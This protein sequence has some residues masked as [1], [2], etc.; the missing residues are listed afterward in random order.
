MEEINVRIREL[1]QEKFDVTELEIPNHTDFVKDLGID[2]LDLYELIL[3]V[4]KE[5]RITITDE[6]AEKLRT[7]G[8]LI[9]FVTKELQH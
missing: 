5:F 7:V 8:S 6:Q 1:I 2:S 9:I 3:A 4:E